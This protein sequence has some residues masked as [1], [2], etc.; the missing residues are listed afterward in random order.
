MSLR[1]V[2][3]GGVAC[4]PKAGCRVKRLLP[5]AMVTMI[6]RDELIAYGGCGIPY[7][8]SGDVPE[9]K[10]LLT[11]SF[12]MTRDA[13]FFEGAKGIE[14]LTATEAL[15][16]DR[17]QKKVRV[18]DLE[19]GGE[20]DIEYDKLVLT[21]GSRPN[22]PPIEGIDLDGIVAVGNLHDAQRIQGMVARGRVGTAAVVG[23]GATGL[24]MAEALADLW[25]IETHVFEVAD[26]VLPGLLDADMAR[27]VEANLKA[28]GVR[29]HV[30]AKIE[31]FEGSDGVVKRVVTDQGTCEVDLVVGTHLHG[32]VQP[33]VIVGGREP[34]D[35]AHILGAGIAI[36]AMLQ[37]EG[38]RG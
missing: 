28:G 10:G 37:R 25:G 8:V 16:V 20:R 30:G 12:H 2:I 9:L 3:I 27:M 11:T 18:K 23:A 14:A 5:D 36:D 31:R 4:G 26:H 17:V 35:E 15:S 33:A 6:D 1:V 34:G 29:V 21:T 22:R 19:T 13:E 32:V 24:E 38:V 7:Y